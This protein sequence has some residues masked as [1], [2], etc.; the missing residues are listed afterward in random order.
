MPTICARSSWLIRGST[1]FALL[2]LPKW[3]SSKRI[4]AKRFS[5]ESKNWSTRVARQDS[6]QAGRPGQSTHDPSLS[7]IPLRLFYSSGTVS[8][9]IGASDTVSRVRN[10]AHSGRENEQSRSS[11]SRLPRLLLCLIFR[12][13]ETSNISSPLA[14]SHSQDAHSRFLPF[15]LPEP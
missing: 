2:S 11:G 7:H 15:R 9:G 4:R 1:G 13:G 14:I 6:D 10:L 8:Q 12:S 3:E 5:L